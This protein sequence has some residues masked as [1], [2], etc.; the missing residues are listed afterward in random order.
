MYNP[1]VDQ[2]FAPEVNYLERCLGALPSTTMC[3]IMAFIG[4]TSQS[5]QNQAAASYQ[6]HAV[7]IC[8]AGSL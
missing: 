5:V 4:G 1:T 7:W 6:E 3:V 8:G 2:L